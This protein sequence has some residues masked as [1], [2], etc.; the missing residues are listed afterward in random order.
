[1]ASGRPPSPAPAVVGLAAA[2]RHLLA[3]RD[4]AG[5]LAAATPPPV[6]TLADAIDRDL[7]IFRLEQALQEL[8][9]A[10]SALDGDAPPTA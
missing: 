4:A 10:L 7:L 1:M 6:R 8:R 5:P 2:A 9:A 3:L